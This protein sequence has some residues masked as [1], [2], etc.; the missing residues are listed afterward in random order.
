MVQKNIQHPYK[1]IFMDCNMPIMDG[2]TAS[3]KI[4]QIYKE[5]IVM[6]LP[7]ICAVTGH[8]D[9]LFI[10]KARKHGM[11]MVVKKPAELIQIK[12]I[13]SIVFLT[14]IPII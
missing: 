7:L 12:E 3:S 8:T 4:M 9:E 10:Q 6:T 1:L 13:L 2:Y 5:N 11:G 14:N